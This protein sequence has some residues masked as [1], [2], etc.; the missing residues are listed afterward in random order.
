MVRR[1]A[2]VLSGFLFGC[3]AATAQV[4][5]R[6]QTSITQSVLETQ[7]TT[8]RGNTR[9]EAIA[10]NDRGRVEDTLPLEHIW[11]QLKRSPEQQAVLDAFTE[12]LHDP[13]SPNF[14]KWIT[15]AQYGKQ[16]GI[17][18]ADLST[19]TGWLESHGFHV[20][21]TY[22]NLVVDFS[23]TAGQVREAFHTEIHHLDVAGKTH[24]ANMSDPQIP[25]ALA[26]V[27]A[28]VKSLNDFRP[29]PLLKARSVPS[30]TAGSGYY[31][32]TPADLATIYDLNPAFSAG[33][34]GQGQTIALVEP[35]NL[36]STGDWYYFRTALG[37]AKQFPKG[38]LVVT[39]PGGGTAG[40]CADPGVNGADGEATLDVEWASASA[41]SATIVLASC[42][43]T[44]FNSG[45]YIALENLLTNGGKTPNVVSISYD[46][47]EAQ[48]GSGANA[49][50][51][52][53]Y[54]LAVTEGVSIFVATGDW[55][56]A[57]SDEDLP[58]AT[59]GIG[60][61]GLGSTIYNVAVGG[62]DFA[63]S[64]Y[65]TNGKYWSGNNGKYYGSALSYIPEIPW[66]DSC[67]SVLISTYVGYAQTYGSSG[68]CNSSVGQQL[69]NTA[70]GSGGPSGCGT[71]DPSVPEVVS[72]SC[73]GYAKP[74]W[75]KGLF[76][77]PADGVRDVPDVSL[78]AANGIW[79][80][81]YV[82]CYTDPNGGG[83]SCFGPPSQWAGFGGTSVSTPVMAGIQAL[84]NQYTG[85]SW[86]NPNPTYYQL[87]KT[88]YRNSGNSACN[89]TGG[90]GTNC[91]FHDVTV[92]DMDVPCVGSVNCY[93][94]SGTFGV[95]STSNS[96]YRPA[97]GTNRGWDFSTGIG[98]V[99]GWNLMK[100]F[101]A[102]STAARPLNVQLST[103]I[104]G[105]N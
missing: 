30:Y 94:P 96:A 44:N 24:I 7:L 95:L 8:L 26:S 50:V 65:G 52:E 34:S 100:G 77:N 55:G 32:I 23:G 41:P 5:E 61:N 58:Y 66:N 22:P 3:A 49:Y 74:S 87:A 18:A 9:P 20:N 45:L 78:F 1:L 105:G 101:K 99:D 73:K 80:H 39:H 79:G 104:A 103:G 16:F 72:G 10:K 91:V 19:V 90:S 46:S 38:N 57:G 86:G 42:A 97:Y 40:A 25:A 36:Y 85:Q 6:A 63:D 37:L 53:L 13:Q 15:A 56:A 68:F 70:A 60:I 33:Y 67:A 35:T 89:S 92:G 29:R 75:Q 51:A 93:A 11:L 4:S 54:N 21:H 17:S 31:L 98:T 14:H 62:T 12:E 71:G 102:T 84:I 28:G 83:G 48:N 82:V 27:V 81:Y 47:S 76:G 88:E 43:D 64:Y 69:I 2:I 59:H